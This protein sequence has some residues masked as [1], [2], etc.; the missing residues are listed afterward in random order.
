MQVDCNFNTIHNEYI[1][2]HDRIVI[3]TE[4]AVRSIEFKAMTV[5]LPQDALRGPSVWYKRYTAH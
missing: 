2:E 4:V 3:F 1:Y 5:F